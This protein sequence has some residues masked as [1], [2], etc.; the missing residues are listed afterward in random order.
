MDF[1]FLSYLSSL[2]PHFF[3]RYQINANITTYICIYLSVVCITYFMNYNQQL[4]ADDLSINPLFIIYDSQ[5]I[6]P[7]LITCD[8]LSTILNIK[9]RNI[10]I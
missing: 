8:C 7:L 2:L 9:N 4:I 3:S 10:K 5:S 1:D 6:F